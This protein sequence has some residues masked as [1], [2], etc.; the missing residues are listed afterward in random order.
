MNRY[1]KQALASAAAFVVSL[2]GFGESALNRAFKTV[3]VRRQSASQPLDCRNILK[4]VES[5][6]KTNLPVAVKENSLD[7]IDDIYAG[8]ILLANTSPSNRLY[9][10]ETQPDLIRIQFKIL[11]AL[12]EIRENQTR[13]PSDGKVEKRYRLEKESLTGWLHD[14]EYIPIVRETVTNTALLK[15][16][17]PP[18]GK[19]CVVPIRLA[20]PR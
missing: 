15:E 17:F 8:M 20:V 12:F 5:S 2:H 9:W 14:K 11:Q 19:P 6:A 18:D 13:L 1:Q 16:L 10:A 3:E 4:E 7:K